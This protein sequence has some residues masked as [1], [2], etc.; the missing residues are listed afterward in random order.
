[1]VLVLYFILSDGVCSVKRG[2]RI[3]NDFNDFDGVDEFEDSF[4]DEFNPDELSC[5]ELAELMDPDVELDD[6]GDVSFSDLGG[7]EQKIIVL[8]DE[9]RDVD[10]YEID[11]H[12]EGLVE[13]AK[14]RSGNPINGRSSFFQYFRKDLATPGPITTISV[15]SF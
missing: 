13:E 15:S 10:P 6:V 12:H 11:E 8:W 4:P 3:V 5:R 1:M 2:F 14:F 7:L 9:V